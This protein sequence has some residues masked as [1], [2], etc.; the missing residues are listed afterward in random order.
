M[1]GNESKLLKILSQLCISSVNSTSSGKTL[2]SLET[3]LHTDRKI[4]KDL[5][6]HMKEVT[7]QNQKHLIFLTGSSGDG[8]SHLFSIIE[9]KEPEL[10]KKFIKLFDATAS[11]EP[12]KNAIETL[13]H[14]LESF[15]D[16]NI[17][18]KG[19]DNFIILAINL[20]IL[21]NFIASK[22]TKEKFT[23]LIEFVK[24]S[25]IYDAD[26][27]SRVIRSEKNLPFSIIN[28]TGYNDL[29]FDEDKIIS[30][31]YNQIFQKITNTNET[32]PFR[33]A[34]KFDKDN[35]NSIQTRILCSNFEMLENEE[36]QKSIIKLL[37]IARVQNKT[38]ITTRLLLDFI[39]RIMVPSNIN[40]SNISENTVEVY[41]PFLLFEAEGKS[42]L[43]QPFK[44]L[45][46]L[47]FRNEE[48]DNIINEYFLNNTK[49][50]YPVEL[51]D[52]KFGRIFANNLIKQTK[53]NK[54]AY[55]AF[56]IRLAWLLNIIKIPSFFND[57]EFYSKLLKGYY[58]RSQSIL[59]KLD[60]L[61]Q[62]AFYSWFGDYD[63]K[64]VYIG[65]TIK[66]TKLGYNLDLNLDYDLIKIDPDEN[67]HGLL[68]E[69]PLTYYLDSNNDLD[70][71]NYSE[72]L[73]LNYNL[74]ILIKRIVEDNYK[75]SIIDDDNYLSFVIFAKQMIKRGQN[76][77]SD[78]YITN[79]LKNSR[80]VL[81]K[82]NRSYRKN[83]KFLKN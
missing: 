54:T 65:N 7:T 72:K 4:Q 31:F 33:K 32:N 50:K 78:L 37:I 53:N 69:I 74:I 13:M 3:Y 9:K 66:N 19:S 26:K 35:V 24:E 64:I 22:G 25:K 76:S 59:K 62:H 15:S 61:I 52:Y 27:T 75:P 43:D 44:D 30:P 83:F 42:R 39:Y 77:Q 10:S 71:N 34:Y 47:G 70:S 16:E 63:S 29:E 1:N 5:I 28:F 40:D 17:E 55:C 41:L 73:E 48:I 2:T 12:S 36:I 57:Y 79:T 6:K 68:F 56:F 49:I 21:N 8:K 60:E 58:T 11:S 82:A 46:I 20:G 18:K 45:D 67:N 81:K 14:D 51:K 80:F 23:K 38:I